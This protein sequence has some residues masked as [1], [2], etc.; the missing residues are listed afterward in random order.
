MSVCMHVKQCCVLNLYQWGIGYPGWKESIVESLF[1]HSLSVMWE[2]LQQ[3]LLRLCVYMCSS[4]H[5]QVVLVHCMQQQLLL[6]RTQG[7]VQIKTFYLQPYSSV[8]SETVNLH[9][10]TTD[11]DSL[12]GV[13]TAFDV[14]S[15]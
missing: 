7:S 2:I 13:L 1:F 14:S 15:T 9:V 10:N 12:H 8:T 3:P 11:A 5:Q 6:L 4:E